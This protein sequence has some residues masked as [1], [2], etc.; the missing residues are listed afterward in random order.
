MHPCLGYMHLSPS[1]TNIARQNRPRA[2]KLTLPAF[3]PS[4]VVELNSRKNV[5]YARK[6]AG[7]M[8]FFVPVHETWRGVGA[9]R[10]RARDAVTA[11]AATN[12]TRRKCM[13]IGL[14]CVNMGAKLY[15]HAPCCA[16]L[17][18][19]QSRRGMLLVAG[20]LACPVSKCQHLCI[21]HNHNLSG[22]IT[23]AEPWFERVSKSHQTP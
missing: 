23:G 8:I 19:P 17:C 18:L 3:I 11:T 15:V 10:A 22:I 7:G 1:H 5:W 12:S 20:N 6:P 4:R 21:C 13:A 9:A 14:G 16:V 2:S